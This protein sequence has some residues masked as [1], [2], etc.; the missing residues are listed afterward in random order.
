[1]E[2]TDEKKASNKRH[3][4]NAENIQIHITSPAKV[5]KTSTGMHR[6]LYAFAELVEERMCTKNPYTTCER[7]HRARSGDVH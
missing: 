7:A 1:M 2:R 5:L 3:T 4:I 6:S